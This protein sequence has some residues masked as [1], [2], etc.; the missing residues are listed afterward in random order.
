MITEVSVC[1]VYTAATHRT[2]GDPARC[3]ETATDGEGGSIADGLPDP[4]RFRAVIGGEV[5]TDSMCDDWLT[6]DYTCNGA[7]TNAHSVEVL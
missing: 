1:W 4:T 3:T 5:I 7:E 2:V 6:I